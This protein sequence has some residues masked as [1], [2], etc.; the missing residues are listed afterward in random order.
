MGVLFQEITGLKEKPDPSEEKGVAKWYKPYKEFTVASNCI[1]VC[2]YPALFN[3]PSVQQTLEAFTAITGRDSTLKDYLKVGERT[4]CVQRAFN[5][6]EGFT[7]KDDTLPKR[8]LQ[9][10]VKGGKY[11]GQR[12][13]NF[14]AM[15][16]YYYGESGFDTK[17]GWP[18][19]D[20]L[21]EVGLEDVADDLYPRYG[22]EER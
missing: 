1:G 6:R 3:I 7:R 22:R 12:I 5:A 16:D 18:T 10:P 14:D 4:I 9:E 19:K 2:L 20:K 17:T 11:D 8:I 21:S 15:L 13:H